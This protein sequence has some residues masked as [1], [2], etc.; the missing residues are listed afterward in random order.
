MISH[1]EDGSIEQLFIEI[2]AGSSL[3]A[4]AADFGQGSELTVEASTEVLTDAHATV[5]IAYTTEAGSSSATLGH[6]EG[7]DL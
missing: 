3:T 2:V 5:R 1:H 7:P 6:H 4:V